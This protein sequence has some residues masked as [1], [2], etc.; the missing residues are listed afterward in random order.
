VFDHFQPAAVLPELEE[1]VLNGYLTGLTDGG[2]RG[3]SDL[4]RLGMWASAVKY[5][6]LT[7]A[8][9]AMATAERQLAYGG[10]VE[11]DAAYR[12][13]ERG[14]ALLYNCQ[15]GLDAVALAK[16]LGFQC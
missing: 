7:P 5:D 13:R 11:V 16:R 8:M 6:W 9:L 14:A 10:T 1:A 2:W 12:F 4:V 3:D 15:R